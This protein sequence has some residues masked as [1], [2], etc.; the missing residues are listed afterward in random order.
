MSWPR[1]PAVLVPAADLIVINHSAARA[2]RLWPSIQ[3]QL[4]AARVEYQA[5]ETQAP[6]DATIKTRAA[7]RSGVA[8][9]VVVGGD[10]TLGETAE[11]FFEFNNDIDIP[12]APINPAATLAL[13]PAGTGNDFARGLRGK[14]TPLHD[15]I[16]TVIARSRGEDVA[17]IRTM[18][19]LY[20]RCNTYEKPFICFN[21]STMGIGGETAGRVAAQ[22]KFMRNFSGEFRF[23]CAAVGALAA[24]RERRVRITVDGRTV[25]DGPMNLVA[26]AN[27]LYCGGGMMLSPDARIDDGKLDVITASGLSRANVVTELSRVHTGGHVHN[28]KVTIT[29]GS[30]ARIETFLQQDAMPLEADGNV[31]GVTPVQF[32]VLPRALRFVSR[33]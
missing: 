2:R 6:G 3:K 27:G 23:I 25:T 33:A 10:G 11:G 21:A 18:D 8:S 9:V 30:I 29:Q 20:G 15:W 32:Q 24:W 16:E 26:V 19:V 22:G 17:T 5:Y 12:P 13:L 31:R 14:H 1:P 7:L 28:P 4:D